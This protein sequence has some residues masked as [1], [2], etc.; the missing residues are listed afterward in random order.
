MTSVA[1]GQSKHQHPPHQWDTRRL[2]YKCNGVDPSYF[3]TDLTDLDPG[4]GSKYVIQCVE[5]KQ[6]RISECGGGEDSTLPSLGIGLMYCM[7]LI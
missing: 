3:L 1:G 7:Q 4:F 5:S 2:I 6:I